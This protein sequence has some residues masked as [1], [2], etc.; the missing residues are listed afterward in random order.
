M[1]KASSRKTMSRADHQHLHG[2]CSSALLVSTGTR[3]AGV[4]LAGTDGQHGLLV[5]LPHLQTQLWHRCV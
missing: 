4:S 3:A 5:K 1:K 2:L